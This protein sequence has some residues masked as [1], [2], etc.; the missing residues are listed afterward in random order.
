MGKARKVKVKV[1]E[2]IKLWRFPGLVSVDLR[3]EQPIDELIREL[4][5]VQQE[6]KWQGYRNIK[7]DIDAG[8]EEVQVE[9]SGDRP[10]TA[11]EEQRRLRNAERAKQKRRESKEKKSDKE[12]QLYERLKAKF[13]KA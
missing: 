2:E 9:F 6:L 1:H 8:Y 5:K 3:G 10:E 11:E 7:I 4:Q 12:R 13:E